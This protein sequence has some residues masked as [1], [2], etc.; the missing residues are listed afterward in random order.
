MFPAYIQSGLRNNL[1]SNIGTQVD[2]LSLW[3]TLKV[4]LS[5][6]GK[7]RNS[8]NIKIQPAFPNPVGINEITFTVIIQLA[9]SLL[10]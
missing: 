9:L 8:S 2:S 5:L 4:A 7:T 6:E 3:E 1:V 10:T